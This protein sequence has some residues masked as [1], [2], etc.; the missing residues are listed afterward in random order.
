MIKLI[1]WD[2]NGTVIN[3]VDTSVAAVNDM[4]KVRNLPPTDKKHYI[5]N[6][7]MPLDKYYSTI[8]IHN[9]DI[10]VLSVEFR[11]YCLKN[12]NLS[13]IFYDFPKAIETS[14]KMGINNILMSSLYEQY[15]FQETKKYDLDKYFDTIIGMKDTGVGSKTEN[16]K[17]YILKNG[18]KPSEVLFIGDLLSDADMAKQLGAK[19]VLVPRGH[20]SQKRCMAAKVPIFNDLENVLKHIDDI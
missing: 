12:E 2:F 20:M 7:I 11:K 17:S 16:A 14:K 9:I 10:S 15:L 3:D 1:I 13:E 4:L 5:E 18:Y 19:C 8:G 6:L